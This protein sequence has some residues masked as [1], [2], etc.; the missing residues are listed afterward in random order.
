[1]GSKKTT[2][3]KSEADWK[4]ESKARTKKKK[5]P[6]KKASVSPFDPVE[7]PELDLDAMNDDH[8]EFLGEDEINDF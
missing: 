1:M 6:K 7:T 8:P 4:K 3:K 2:R 5:V